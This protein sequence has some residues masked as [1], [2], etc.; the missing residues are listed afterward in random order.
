MNDFL[1]HETVQTTIR[2]FEILGTIGGLGF[3]VMVA[4]F[5][6]EEHRQRRAHRA[7]CKKFNMRPRF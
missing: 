2:V 6:L 4:G 7:Y 5:F 3:L 1:Q